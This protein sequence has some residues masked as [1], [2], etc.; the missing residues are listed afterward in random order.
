MEAI[1][2]MLPTH[3]PTKWNLTP[4]TDSNL[5]SSFI[6][7]EAVLD[8]TTDTI[9]RHVTAAISPYIAKLQNTEEK[10]TKLITDINTPLNA[11]NPQLEK[12][13]TMM[14]NL[15]ARVVKSIASKPSYANVLTSGQHPE[16]EAQIQQTQCMARE[17]IKDRQIMIGFTPNSPLAAGKLSHVQLVE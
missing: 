7:E 15:S 14:D 6:L 4:S 16:T 8:E 17:A 3:H 13:Q 2:K 11:N 1:T 10:L 12:I 5:H 9:A